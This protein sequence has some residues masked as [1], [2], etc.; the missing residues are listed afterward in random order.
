LLN[1]AKEELY[2]KSL[3]ASYKLSRCLSGSAASIKT[4]LHLFDH[5]IKPIILYGSDI[6]G[7]FET[8]SA[9]CKKYPINISEKHISK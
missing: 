9:T 7:L 1:Y 8:D 2:N 3:K 6:W 5:T 4:N